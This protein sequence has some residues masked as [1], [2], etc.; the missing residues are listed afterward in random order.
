MEKSEILTVLERATPKNRIASI[1]YS[2]ISRLDGNPRDG[3]TLLYGYD[4]DQATCHVYLTEGWEEVVF[5]RYDKNRTILNTFRFDFANPDKSS[6]VSSGNLIPFKRL[7]PEACD[8]DLCCLLAEYGYH[9]EFAAHANRA[10]DTQF[11]GL[12]VPRA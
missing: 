3:R 12:T 4:Y 8:F 2:L 11:W 6:I 5:V 10:C 9:L 1:L 7:Y